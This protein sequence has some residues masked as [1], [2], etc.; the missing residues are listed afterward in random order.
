VYEAICSAGP[1]DL[2]EVVEALDGLTEHLF[3][4]SRLSAYLRTYA[5]RAPK[6]AAGP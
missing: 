6:E 4:L 2:S 3:V 1:A 5:T